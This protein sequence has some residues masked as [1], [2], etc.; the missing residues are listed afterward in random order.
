MT[1]PLPHRRTKRDHGLLY[2]L[3]LASLLMLALAQVPDGN[4][5][6]DPRGPRAATT[7]APA[8][9]GTPSWWRAGY[10]GDGTTHEQIGQLHWPPVAYT[11]FEGDPIYSRDLSSPTES[12][13]FI[14]N[15]THS[16]FKLVFTDDPVLP[17]KY[18]KVMG[19]DVVALGPK[20]EQND[21]SDLL[22]R[23]WLLLFFVIFLITGI[24]LIPCIG[25]CYCCLCC[26][27]RCKQGCPTCTTGVDFRRRMCCGTCLAILVAGLCFGTYVAFV[28][29][30]FLNRGFHDS[31]MTMKRGSEDTCVFL[32]D[33]ADHI[34][35]LF[36]KNFMELETHVLDVLENADKHIFL[37][38]A[39]TSDSNALAELERILDNMPKALFIM[40]NV[41]F[42]EKELRF[43]GSQ[44]R[45]V[46]RGLK[47]DVEHACSTLIQRRDVFLYHRYGHIT[48]LPYSRC[49]YYDQVP[50]TTFY[51]EAIEKIIKGKYFEIPK[52]GIA[53]LKLVSD[54][55]RR[56]MELIIPPLRRDI[57]RGRGV[58]FKYASKIR[59]IVDAVISDIHLNTMR[60]TKTYD[61]VYEKFGQD[62][63]QIYE[64]TCVLLF[65]LIIVLIS[66]LL[67]GCLGPGR[68]TAGA[69]GFCSK[70]TG[71]SCLLM[72]MIIIFCIYSFITLIALFYLLLGLVTYEGACAPSSEGDK[73]TLF[74]HLDSLIDLNLFSPLTDETVAPPMRMSYAIRHCQANESIFQLLRSND[75]FNIDDLTR[76]Q[77]SLDDPRE[78]KEFTDD[79]SM[80]YLLT[81]EE[82]TLLREVS[83]GNL[84]TYHSSSYLTHLCTK[85]VTPHTLV[86]KIS[87]GLRKI[88]EEVLISKLNYWTYHGSRPPYYKG[89]KTLHYYYW[90]A[91]VA[92]HNARIDA[93]AIHNTF[94]DRC[95]ALVKKIQRDIPKVDQLILYENLDFGD[96]IDTLLDAV[97]RAEKFIQERGKEYI[98]NLSQNLTDAI[99]KEIREYLDMIINEANVH[100]GHCQ[101]LAYIYYRGV[102]FVCERLVNP[103]NNAWVG[104]LLCSLLFL[105][106]LYICHRLMCLYLKIHPTATVED[107]G[108]KCPICMVRGPSYTPRPPGTDFPVGFPH[109]PRH[110]QQQ[111]QQQQAAQTQLH[112]EKKSKR[113][114]E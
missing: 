96:S 6:Y 107:G 4:V 26:C 3:V 12:V 19:D 72:A 22:A 51:V 63:E 34:T 74:R 45:Y 1:P 39:D 104:M 99:N 77:M 86:P 41:D 40:R 91:H 71:A 79:L 98:N 14:Y 29:N 101:P 36:V 102:S 38:L 52:R 111:Q 53:R 35:H 108:H 83:D 8:D 32:K 49:L 48:R 43:C 58:L 56:Q 28:S 94:D 46:L 85:F 62:R 30:K 82:K 18:I 10:E 100:V 60:T 59:N 114:R 33:V 37:D 76:L 47:R 67:C 7:Q 80:I 24:I 55:I 113:K 50:N 61:D 23:Y 103:L 106:I 87:E 68:T 42:N 110:L 31:T 78:T 17:Q 65:I 70:G 93:E 75:L 21:W 16:L 11:K 112:V 95:S 88:A 9:T 69:F 54:K 2:V 20:V 57:G 13:N 64:F 89:W 73:N 81:D 84:S 90:N 27:R 97:L 15:F 105:P 92:L 25:V 109:P 5:E 66:G 44:Y